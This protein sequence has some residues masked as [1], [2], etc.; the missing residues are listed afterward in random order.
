M[1]E[2]DPTK[3]N[4]ECVGPS[5]ENAGKA[6]TC[7]GCPN[8]AACAAGE[9]REVDPT[10]ALVA[11]RLSNVKHKLLVL[12]GKGGVGKST[13]SCQLAFALAARGY[14]VGLLDVDLCGPSVPRMLG[15]KG[16]GV[17]RSSSGWSPVYLESMPDLGV[18][19]VGFMLPEDDKAVI[20]RGPRKN[21]LIKQFLTEV[22][23]GDLD[24]LVID[25]PPGTSDEHISLAQYLKLA[26]VSGC[27]V[28]TT[29]QEIAM[30]D[31]RKELNFCQKT[32]LP[33]LGVIENMANIVT[34]LSKCT[35]IDSRDHS[36]LDLSKYLPPDL[37]QSLIIQHPIFPHDTTWT[38]EQMAQTY[39]TTFLG[40]LPL[41]PN[42]AA[43][44]EQGKF[45]PH[46]SPLSPAAKPLATAIDSILQH[47]S[48][49]PPISRFEEEAASPS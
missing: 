37:Q 13:I 10:P 33:I 42:L 9:G 29:P 31:V 19:S 4:A 39:N 3:A 21:G 30:Q 46:C 16:R 44:C 27:L 12:S 1:S 14:A 36:Q 38:P 32:S 45:L 8:A 40:A 23:W 7:A 34:P 15:L 25:T 17:H 18:M 43:A 26:Q 6:S 35:V 24:F 11:E 47:L 22:D 49:A 28:V 20:W 2:I 41:D 5:S 48:C